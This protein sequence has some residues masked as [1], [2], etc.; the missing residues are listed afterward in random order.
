MKILLV[1]NYYQYYGGEET[2]FHSLTKLLRKKGH[3]VILYT[4]DS[5]N[6]KTFWD[7][8]KAGI[9]LF[10]N[11]EI[12]RELSQI[13]K[14]Q[15]PDI[16]H[17]NNIYP[18]I[19]GTAYRVCEKYNIPIIQHIHNYR[20]MCPKGILFREGKVCELCVKK[21]IPFYSI[22]FGC[23]H[24]SRIASLFFS[25]AYF[26]HRSILHTFDKINLSIFPSKFTKNYYLKNLNIPKKKA[27]VIPYFINNEEKKVK[28]VK[29]KDY[30]LFVGRLSEE[31]GIMQLLE[32]FKTLPKE[33][34]VVIGDGPLRKKVKSYRKY[35]N[36]TFVGFLSQNKISKYIEK[37]KAVIIPSIWYE[38]FPL[39]SLEALSQN[40][41]ILIPDNENF[42]LIVKDIKGSDRINYYKFG[43]FNNL[44]NKI[45]SFNQNRD[46]L[47]ELKTVR[48]IFNYTTENHYAAL[49]KLYQRVL[50]TV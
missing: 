45:I 5:K 20:F 37:A 34:L 7:K 43:D 14:E 42:K 6:I 30:F 2:Y 4:K 9:G 31:K 8:T 46:E 13:L 35:K 38:V 29:R 40:T 21:S 32:V 12:E 22:L 1:H 28:K 26:F 39:V 48:Q 15:K 27:I 50:H 10:W 24:Q 11:K 18:L 17:F 41:P 3:K 44:K 16:A 19:G 36:I 49:L 33:K 25:L 47:K 23:Y